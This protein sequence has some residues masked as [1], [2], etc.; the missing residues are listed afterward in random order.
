M[1]FRLHRKSTY[2]AWKMTN[3]YVVD[4]GYRSGSQ[5]IPV[6]EG[7]FWRNLEFFN[8]NIIGTPP[9]G[10]AEKQMQTSL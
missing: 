6:V 4:K 5:S 8:V 7:H 10:F 3:L 1:L 2:C 9:P